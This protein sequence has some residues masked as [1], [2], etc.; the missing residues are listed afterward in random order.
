MKSGDFLRREDDLFV[1]IH[2]W[3]LSLYVDKEKKREGKRRVVGRRIE[4]DLGKTW[5]LLANLKS[6]WS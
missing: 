5:L 6:V 1:C 2:V 3:S 4:P